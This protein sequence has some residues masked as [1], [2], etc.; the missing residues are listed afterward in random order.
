MQRTE[1]EEV[2]M[3][4]EVEKERSAGLLDGQSWYLQRLGSIGTLVGNLS[5]AREV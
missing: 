4:L 3:A 1:G 2:D 5:Q